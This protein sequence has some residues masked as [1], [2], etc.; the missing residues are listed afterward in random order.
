MIRNWIRWLEDCTYIHQKDHNN[1][2]FTKRY[3]VK[4]F[5]IC[6]EGSFLLSEAQQYQ[7]FR[8]MHPPNSTGGCIVII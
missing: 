2:H 7:G 5:P 3:H 4:S 8:A 1:T 6:R